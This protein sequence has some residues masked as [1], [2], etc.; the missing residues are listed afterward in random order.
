MRLYVSLLACPFVLAQ[1]FWTPSSRIFAKKTARGAGDPYRIYMTATAI[2]SP[3]S[4]RPATP[5][6]QLSPRESEVLIGIADGLENAEIA[7]KLYLSHE[8]VKTHA[9][10]VF[11]KLGARNRAHAVML[12]VRCG[13][14]G[15]AGPQLELPSI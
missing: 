4:G 8:T 5:S 14:L 9:S 1:S 11:R 6:G 15:A 3:R 2:S 7:E 12:G 10:S 13:V